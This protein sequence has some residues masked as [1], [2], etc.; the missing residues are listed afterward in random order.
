M[1]RAL[2]VQV[3]G[4]H[5]KT[6]KI[7]P[8]EYNHANGLGFIEGSVV[9]YITR[10]REKNGVEDLLKIKHYVDLLIQL[11]YP[12]W[13]PENE[14]KRTTTSTKARR[15]PRKSVR[16]VIRPVVKP[17]RVARSTRATAK[18]STTSRRSR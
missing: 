18:K 12:E 3:G 4:S 6:Q 16:R 10:F 5:Y 9:K 14:A 2:D 8:V 17:K 7:Q 11:E 13:E 1:K 15:K